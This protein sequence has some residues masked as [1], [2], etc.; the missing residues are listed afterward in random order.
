MDTAPFVGINYCGLSWES[1]FLITQYYLYLYYGDLDLVKELYAADIQWMQKV[2]RIH[3]E[4]WWM[5][6]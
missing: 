4:G 1:A 6:G 5:K 3:P 2:A